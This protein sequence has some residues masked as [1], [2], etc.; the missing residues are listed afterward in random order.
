[1]IVDAFYARLSMVGYNAFPHVIPQEFDAP[2]ITYRVDQDNAPTEY[3]GTR[4]LKE[5]LVTVDCW[6]TS[7]LEAQQMADAVES[8]F[9]DYSGD[10]GGL[11]PAV[12]ANYI[13]KERRFDLLEQATGLYR[14]SLQLFIAYTRG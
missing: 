3:D 14:V 13:R 8:S 10:L 2:A 9:V 7:Y 4:T 1:M 6:S 12:S 11:S 5:A